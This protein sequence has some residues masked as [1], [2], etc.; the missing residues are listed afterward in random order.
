LNR[1]Q[2]QKRKEEEQEE[3]K[4]KKMLQHVER[5]DHS[6]NV[7][8]TMMAGVNLSH[9][10]IKDSQETKSKSPP[11]SSHSSKELIFGTFEVVDVIGNETN[12]QL[13]P[14]N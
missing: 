6:K 1:Q 9:E 8:T 7:N 12:L 3:E 2:K 13:L 5:I 11:N 10:L 14:H 4:K